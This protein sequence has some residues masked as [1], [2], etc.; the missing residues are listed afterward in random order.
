MN[1]PIESNFYSD[2]ENILDDIDNERDQGYH[3]KV[4]DDAGIDDDELLTAYNDYV[5]NGVLNG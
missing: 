1:K 2:L 5:C 4:V 3:D